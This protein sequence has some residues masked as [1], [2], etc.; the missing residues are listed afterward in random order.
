ME[1]KYTADDDREVDGTTEDLTDF[2]VRLIALSLY[3]RTCRLTP[4][5]SLSTCRTPCS[6]TSTN[7]SGPH[8]TTVYHLLPPAINLVSPLSTLL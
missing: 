7:P 3:Y 8:S 4:P 6:P 1:S 2:K 5:V